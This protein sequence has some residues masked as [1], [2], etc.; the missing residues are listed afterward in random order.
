MIVVRPA[1]DLRRGPL[2]HI[3]SWRPSPLIGGNVRLVGRQIRTA[4]PGPV[5]LA[6]HEWPGEAGLWGRLAEKQRGV[7]PRGAA[8]VGVAAWYATMEIPSSRQQ[9][10]RVSE[11]VR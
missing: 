9:W 6:V 4:L 8:S 7:S 11:I 10:S 2:S 1:G 5:V 3:S